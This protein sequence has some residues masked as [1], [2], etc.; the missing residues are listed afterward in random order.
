MTPF[1]QA[2]IPA[3]ER[4]ATRASILE[5]HRR[6]ELLPGKTEAEVV[7][8]LDDVDREDA[9]AVYWRN[10]LYQVRV[11]PV[12]P[13]RSGWPPMVHLSIKR[14]DR[15]PIHD[16]RDLQEIKNRLV[17]PECEAVELYP[18]ESCVVDSANQFHLW[19]LGNAGQ[20]FPFGF[21]ERLVTDL[22]VHKSKNRPRT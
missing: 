18:A 16:W 12:G 15:Q 1:Q 13:P 19:C 8:E 5:A 7:A 4:A 17:G 21:Q 9:D 20:R 22:S 2:E 10:D 3:S 11:C 6:G 14:L